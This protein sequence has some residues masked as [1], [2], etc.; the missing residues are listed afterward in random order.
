MIR[1]LIC[2]LLALSVV[3]AA[4]NSE[5]ETIATTTTTTSTTTTTVPPTTTTTIPPVEIENAPPKL[6]RAVTEFYDYAS[7][8]SESAPE[9]PKRLLASITP[10][11]TDTPVQGVASLGTFHEQGVAVVEMDS[12]VFLAAKKGRKW[13]IV[14]GEW[15]SLGLPSYFGDGPRHV[16]VIGSDAR[17]GQNVTTSRA[18]SIHFVA[19]DGKGGGAVVGLP[20]DSFLPIPGRGRTKITNSL[21]LGGP[22][23][24]MSALSEHTGLPLEGYVITGFAGFESLLT[25]VLGG[26]TVEVPFAINDRWAKVSLSAGQQLL[27]GAQALG[28]ARARKTVPGGDLTRSK[29]QGVILLAAAGVVREMGLAAI[30]GLMEAAEPHLETDLAAGELL[31]FSAMAVTAE[32]DEDDNI[33]APGS[34]GSAGGASVVFLHSSVSDLWEDLADGTLEEEE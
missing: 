16:A 9:L 8:R 14:G 33:V 30:P 18:D 7:A 22:E 1:N 31:T 6:M 27:D 3:A 32:I 34:P 13:L 15:P 25:E 21:A 12:D 19:L 17:R 28:F 5:P 2:L 29:H 24:T 11:S 10:Q 26:V 20:R 23:S 4:C